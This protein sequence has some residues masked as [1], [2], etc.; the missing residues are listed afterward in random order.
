MTIMKITIY[1]NSL[2]QDWLTF[3]PNFLDI[4][5][6]FIEG[7]LIVCLVVLFMKIQAYF[8]CVKQTRRC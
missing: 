4:I 5:L 3:G 1:F 7:K 2:E 6:E 8:R